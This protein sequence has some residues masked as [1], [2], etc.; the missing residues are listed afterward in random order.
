MYYSNAR[1][2]QLQ[3]HVRRRLFV[4]VLLP[5]LLIVL[6][7]SGCS[8]SQR[9]EQVSASNNAAS[10]VPTTPVVPTGTAATPVPGAPLTVFLIMMENHD[11]RDIQGSAS[12]PY[13][14][15][16]LLP[17]ASSAQQYYNP[18]GLHPSEPNYLWLEAGSNLGVRDDAAPTAH[19]FATTNHLV[20]QLQQAH[21]SW[22]SYQEGID[23]SNCP[24]ESVNNYAPKHNPMVFFDDVTGDNDPHSTTCIAHIRPYSELA[25]DLK[26]GNAARYNFLTPD[27]CNDM[28]DSCPP[29]LDSIRQGDAWLQQQIPLIQESHAYQQGGIIFITWDEG[30]GDDGPIGLLMLSPYAKGRGYTNTI[31]YTH[32][33][34]LRTVQELYGVTPLLGDAAHA[35]DLSDLFRAFPTPAKK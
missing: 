6:L 7:F 21:I 23:G 19:H 28:H 9:M 34:L 32:S 16:V 1:S 30:E 33:S 17:Q 3:A 2:L 15:N 20:T 10:G 26:Q 5:S 8:S 11:W 14:N 24:L 18:P 29:T 4:R 13:I 12:A 22:K 31:H 27:L 35:T 25:S